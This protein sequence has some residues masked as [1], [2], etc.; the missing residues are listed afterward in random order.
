MYDSHRHHLA[1][2]KF[3]GLLDT[4]GC[5]PNQM[6]LNDRQ[7]PVQCLTTSLALVNNILPVKTPHRDGVSKSD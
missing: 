6:T 1:T 2:K 4:F 5:Q 7:L 3:P